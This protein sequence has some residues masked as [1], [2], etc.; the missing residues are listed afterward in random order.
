LGLSGM[1]REEQYHP[2]FRGFH[3]LTGEPLV[4]NAG[5][6]DRCA[7]WE[8]CFTP[9]K[10]VSVLLSQLP[11]DA[12]KRLEAL[13]WRAVEDTLRLMA[14]RFAFSRTGKAS[15]G[16]EHVPVGLVLAMF[17]HASSRAQDPN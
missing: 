12:R 9:W 14:R 16:C 11:P 17:E 13:N 3:P 6:P 8:G 5:K 7:G 1:V 4:Q 2:V 15:E 10:D